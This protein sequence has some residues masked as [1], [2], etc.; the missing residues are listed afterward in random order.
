MMS[1]SEA[2]VHLVPAAPKRA[3]RILPGLV[4][5]AGQAPPPPTESRPR[6]PGL[7]R[8]RPLT[9]A[10]AIDGAEGAE[11][12]VRFHKLRPIFFKKIDTNSLDVQISWIKLF[13]EK[14]GRGL[15]Y[16]KRRNV[17]ELGL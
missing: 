10:P 17:D 7:R 6:P 16:L 4:L 11:S 2:A 9:S 12:V 1:D 13:F 14:I 5:P 8:I 15:S 3:A